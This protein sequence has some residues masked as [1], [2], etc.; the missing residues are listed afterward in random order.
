MTRN[1]AV[2][3][4]VKASSVVNPSKGC[5][6]MKSWR[7]VRLIQ[8]GVLGGEVKAFC[9]SNVTPLSPVWKPRWVATPLSNAH[10]HPHQE[11]P[12][13]LDGGRWSDSSRNIT[14]SKVNVQW[15]TTT[16][17]RQVILDGI[18]PRRVVCRRSKSPLTSMPRGINQR[19]RPAIRPPTCQK[20]TTRPAAV[21]PMLKSKRWEGC[22]KPTPEDLKRKE[23]SSEE[24]G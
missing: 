10:H 8:A 19:Q 16:S 2:V 13:V 1:A 12:K 7:S 9:S 17:A 11:E 14:S 24:N 4:S 23:R 22:P 20:I 3:E 21:L 18:P 5:Q 15:R 6:P